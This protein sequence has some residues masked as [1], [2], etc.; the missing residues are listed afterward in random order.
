MA[1]VLRHS[2]CNTS[3][4]CSFTQTDLKLFNKIISA[5]CNIFTC[6]IR[7]ENA[8]E[9]A[10]ELGH[11]L[12]YRGRNREALLKFLRSIPAEELTEKMNDYYVAMKT[13]GPQKVLHIY[14]YYIF[15]SD[16]TD[17]PKTN[18]KVYLRDRIK[19]NTKLD[20]FVLWI[21]GENHFI[22]NNS[23]DSNRIRGLWYETVK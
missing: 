12:G 6:P 16:T 15:I 21:F 19:E 14:V 5:S 13:V 17:E 11:R 20:S 1:S 18:S 9:P 7:K 3:F 10:F 23:S 2:T 4:H 22:S 8:Q